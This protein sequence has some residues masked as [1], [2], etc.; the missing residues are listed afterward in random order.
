[1]NV[2]SPVRAVAA[3]AL[4]VVVLSA[5]PAST[6]APKP[7]D[8]STVT[9]VVGPAGGSL[10][11]PTGAKLV[12]P[13]GALT[14]DVELSMTGA[15]AP[16][17]AQAGAPS[18]GQAFVLGPDGQQF[19]A[20]LLIEV[21]VDPALV[22]QLGADVDDLRLRLA[23]QDTLAF[24]ELA[25]TVDRAREVLTAQLTHFSVIV[26]VASTNPFTF[27]TTGLPAASVGVAYSGAVLVSGGTAPY[28]FTVVAGPLPPGLALS[29]QG[30]FSG[31]PTQAGSFVFTVRVADGA[32]ASADGVVVMDVGGVGQCNSVP[33]SG[34]LVAEQRVA[35]TAPVPA[36][37]TVSPGTWVRAASTIYTGVGGVTGPTGRQVRQAIRISEV[38][39]SLRFDSVYQ[40]PGDALDLVSGSA[41]FSGTQLTVT[42]NCPQPGTKVFGYSATAGTVTFY[43]QVSA[44]MREMVFVPEGT[45]AV[46]AG[47]PADGGIGADAGIDAGVDAG[48]GVEFIGDGF[49]DL[50]DLAFDPGQASLYTLG[51]GA[52]N[53]C[54]AAACGGTGTGT[55]VTNVYASSLAVNNGTLFVTTDFQNVK[56]CDV[57]G[58]TLSTFAALGA[59]TYP[60]HLVVANSRVYWLA[61]AGSS[62]R[63]QACPLTG[64]GAGPTTVYSGTELDGV[65]VTGV[66]VDAAAVYVSGFTG[67]LWR[68]PLSDPDTASGPA[69]SL[70][71]SAYGTGGLVV[72]GAALAWT[73]INDNRV[74]ACMLPSCASTMTVR[75]GLRSPSALAFDAAT[76]YGADRGTPNGTGGYVAG[77]GRVW[78][79]AK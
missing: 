36:G 15:A 17:A 78:K 68:I 54:G 63:I 58:C 79:F 60:A 23:P 13:A 64:C 8:T 16:S 66:A 67:G 73:E 9:Q 21:P 1:M 6:P 62:R 74:M 26:P 34:N 56:Q 39:G 76:V 35:T 50:V 46:D 57:S 41:A 69:T 55:L 25:T 37:G 10:Q 70:T 53:R 33:N 2:S 4:F 72:D 71:S 11:H 28:A 20:P 42:F 75:T 14:A 24:V 32:G 59:N 38:G 45:T 44:G 65:P 18:V 30:V 31:T 52:V 49:T 77:T 43:E 51:G 27:S 12:V 19:A 22:Q 61:E 5:C 29:A 7:L 47:T 3:A 40:E 48:L